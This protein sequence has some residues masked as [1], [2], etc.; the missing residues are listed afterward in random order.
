MEMRAPWEFGLSLMAMPVLWQAPRGDGHP[1]LVFPGLAASD[2]STVPLRRFLIGRGYD[3][4][5]WGLGRNLGP[6]RGVLE[7]IFE[8]VRTAQRESG[9]KVSLVGWSLGGIYAR[10]AAKANADAVRCVITLGTPFSG[11]VQA[12]N[13]WRVYELASG[14]KADARAHTMR[15]AEAPPV[16]TT[17]IYSRTDGIVAWEC[18][19]QAPGRRRDTENIE[20]EA[21]HLGIGVNPAALFAVADRLAQPLGAWQPFD[22]SGWKSVFY[23]DPARQGWHPESWYI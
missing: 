4:R 21:S 7:T 13:A 16:P 12:T 6:G 22:R 23:G 14:E 11:P 3:V 1:I 15:L 17:S 9:R 20:V 19:I 2:V 5:P 18:S 8:M 10:E